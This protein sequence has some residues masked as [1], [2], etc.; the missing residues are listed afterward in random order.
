MAEKVEAGELT[1]DLMREWQEDYFRAA[2]NYIRARM[3]TDRWIYVNKM[4]SDPKYQQLRKMR[5]SSIIEF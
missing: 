5:Y 4:V 3:N 2:E 1:E